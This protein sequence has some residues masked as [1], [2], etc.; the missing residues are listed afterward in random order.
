MMNRNL[1]VT[2]VIIGMGLLTHCTFRSTPPKESEETL[3]R[4]QSVDEPPMDLPPGNPHYPHVPAAHQITDTTMPTD[5][6]STSKPSEAVTSSN[7]VIDSPV[8]TEF[9]WPEMDNVDRA[10]KRQ[11]LQDNRS[12]DTTSWYNPHLDITYTLTPTDTYKNPQGQ[13]CRKFTLVKSKAGMRHTS[14]QEACRSNDG[15]WGG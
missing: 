13:L 7:T 1:I 5:E 6:E 9:T 2:A 4:L 10:K 3:V 12:Y 8:K 11:A 15:S 14:A